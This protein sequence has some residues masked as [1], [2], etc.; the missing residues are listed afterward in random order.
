MPLTAVREKISYLTQVSC[1]KRV[2]WRH[3]MLHD[4]NVRGVRATQNTYHVGRNTHHVSRNMQKDGT[5]FAHS[6]AN[7]RNIM[8]AKRRWS[9]WGLFAGALMGVGDLTAFLALGLEM[10]LADRS[11]MTEVMVLFMVTY[12][13][14]GFV[15]GKLMEAR[16]KARDDARTIASQLHALEDSQRVAL[17]NEKL[18]AIGRLAA[19]IAHEVRNPLGVIRASASMVREHFSPAEEAHRACDFIRE[20]IDRLNS[21]ITAL[22]TFS[23][24]AELR[25]QPIMIEQVIDRAL[26]LTNDELQRRGITV[27]RESDGTPPTVMADPDLIAQVIFG[28]LINAAEAIG[29][30]GLV[31][32]R[33]IRAREQMIVEVVDT[34]PGIAPADAERIF[35]PF[36]TTKSSGTGLGLPMAARIIRAHGGLIEVAP[37]QGAGKDGVGARFRMR[38]PISGPGELQEQAA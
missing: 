18:A 24:P 5:L 16:A 13:G 15:I 30:H 21:L 29:E 8:Q 27:A 17:Q 6:N 1:L 22:L 23:R 36:F 2:V 12:G 19:G 28:L 7:M 31:I 35:E 4:C 14:L 9:V 11:V 38:L 34:G 25:L 37:G 26:Q 3:S 10:R 33:T 32:L 20:E